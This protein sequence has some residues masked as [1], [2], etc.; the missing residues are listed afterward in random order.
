M[1]MEHWWNRYPKYLPQI[2]EVLEEP[3]VGM[4]AQWRDRW[5]LDTLFL[6]SNLK[7]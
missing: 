4:K 5:E 7:E 3:I 6:D 1:P 2:F